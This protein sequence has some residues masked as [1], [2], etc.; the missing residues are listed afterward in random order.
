M[1]KLKDIAK[2]IVILAILIGGSIAFSVTVEALPAWSGDVTEGTPS[3][4][5]SSAL[6]GFFPQEIGS[7]GYVYCVDAGGLLRW[8]KVDRTRYFP[9]AE[10][11]IECGIGSNMVYAKYSPADVIS[12]AEEYVRNNVNITENLGANCE[13]KG[14]SRADTG[15]II[16]ELDTS[17]GIDPSKPMIIMNNLSVYHMDLMET[18]VKKVVLKWMNQKYQELGSEEKPD[19]LL[20][21]YDLEQRYEY[22]IGE[23]NSKGEV[24]GPK[25]TVIGNGDTTHYTTAWSKKVDSRTTSDFDEIMNAYI[26]NG[27][28]V[29][30]QR[31]N[32]KIYNQY[33]IQTANWLQNDHEGSRHGYNADGTGTENITT[34]GKT[35]GTSNGKVLYNEAKEY[36][37]FNEKL[38]A[39]GKY[40]NMLE[41]DAKSAQVFTNRVDSNRSLDEYIVGP[42]TIKYPEYTNI[43]YLTDIK[44]MGTGDYGETTLS[45]ASQ[46]FEITTASSEE[47]PKD[48]EMFWIR[49]NAKKLQYAEKI[50]INP[51]FEYVLYTT[52]EYNQL[53]GDAHIYTYKGHLLQGTVVCNVR[54][55]YLVDQYGYQYNI[56]EDRDEWGIIRTENRYKDTTVP[57]T[58]YQAYIEM[59]LEEYEIVDEQEIH[60]VY[61][62]HGS[63][64]NEGPESTNKTN[65]VKAKAK[66]ETTFDGGPGLID[67]VIKL[68]GYTWVDG[69]AGKESEYNGK[70]GDSQDTPMSGVKV[71]LHQRKPDGQEN[72]KETTTTD[73]NGH[74]AFEG[75]NAL[76]TYYVEFKYNGQYYQPTI[77]KANG[78][79]WNDS[80]KGNDIL[81]ERD[82]LNAKFEE[83]GSNPQNYSGGQAYTRTYLKENG[84][85]DDFGNP[86]GSN[87][88]VNDCMISAYTGYNKG[89]FTK[90]YYPVYSKFVISDYMSQ[91]N[92]ASHTKDYQANF[93]N[94]YNMLYNGDDTGY[95]NLY[96]NQGFVLRETVDLALHKDVYNATIEIKGK[97]QTYK[98]NKNDKLSDEDFW[99]I[100]TQIS[101]AY[102]SSA[103]KNAKANSATSANEYFNKEDYTREIYKEDYNFKA[104]NY[105]DLS[106][107]SQSGITADKDELRVYVTYKITVRNQSDA[108][109][110]KVMELVD[111]YD[112][113]YTLVESSNNVEREQKYKP[114]LGDRRGNVLQYVTTNSSSKYGASTQASSSEYNQTYITGFD[115]ILLDPDNNKDIYL[116]ITF[117]VNND[118]NGSVI[119]DESVADGDT[120]GYNPK[121]NIVEI[122]GYKTYYT[123]RAVAPN[124]NNDKT[125]TEYNSGDIAGL[126]DIDSI[127]GN[128]SPDSIPVDNRSIDT[129]TFED[130]TSKGPNIRIRL[131]RQN[132]RT[133]DGTVF[134][135][136]RTVTEDSS[137]IG[138]GLRDDG[139]TG[140]NGITVQLVE[141]FKDSSGNYKTDSNTGKPLEYVWREVKSG[142]KSTQNFIIGN[143]AIT[144]VD[145]TYSVQSSGQ[146][147]FKSFAPGDY[148]VRFI[149][150]DGTQSI[151]G[152]TSIDYETGETKSNPITEF[153][154]ANGYKKTSEN[155][156]YY[157][158]NGENIALNENSYNGQDYKSTTY[159]VGVANGESSYRNVSTATY[160][161]DFDKAATGLYSDAKDIYSR[162]LEVNNYSST[163]TNHFAEVLASF[164]YLSPYYNEMTDEQ[165]A[166]VI[167]SL[168]NE[169]INKTYMVAETGVM[170]IELEYNR[171]QDGDK[172]NNYT[173]TSNNIGGSNYDKNGYYDVSNVDFGLAQRPQ[174]QLK[175]TKQIANV[176]VTLANGNTLF[177][178]SKK[179]TNVMW[180]DQKAH[181][182]DKNNTYEI[183]NNYSKKDT[184]GHSVSSENTLVKIPVV[185]TVSNKGRVQLTMDEELMHGSTVQITYMITVAN[186]GEVDYS[187]VE[188]YYTGIENNPSGNIVKTKVETLVDY[189]G[190]QLSDDSNAT[191]NNLQFNAETNPDWEVVTLDALKTAGL[192]NEN[193]TDSAKQYTTIIKTK[194]SSSIVKELV[195]VLFDENNS[196][197]IDDKWNEDP[198]EVLEAVNASNSVTGVKLVLSQTITSGSN[199]DDLT[200][201]NITE[202]VK[203]S[204]VSGRRLAYSV[205]GNQDPTEEPYE[206]DA[207][208]PQE[209]IILPPFGQKVRYYALGIGAGLILIAGI[210]VTIIVTKRKKTL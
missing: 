136:E 187:D 200:Y 127:A 74:Y 69:T 126:I 117:R 14:G 198:L 183:N 162:R 18:Y 110:S 125:D 48:G 172:N 161:Y 59:D 99:D 191:R 40:E 20:D 44:I 82:G 208:S 73:A 3:Q 13:I 176:K 53:E 166:Q 109:S 26:L 134:E 83:I 11:Y 47:W 179:A 133:I 159:Q 41:L 8:G 76:Y 181:G 138:N 19:E 139:E 78:V 52:A 55:N 89:S 79:A 137:Q 203:T 178:A 56:Y 174:S 209:V 67:L 147:L 81:S 12:K 1:K 101:D 148:M 4:E 29:T 86:T 49:V 108:I 91:V 66:L 7:E 168:L 121:R 199:S 21:A 84:I 97:S 23:L 112:K 88:Y 167:Q 113:E 120:N 68:E 173:N 65:L 38:K 163:I 111:Y 152:T 189:V 165:K 106:V 95:N 195:P 28:K 10:D 210:V 103:Y 185:R 135:D 71:I 50:A 9:E 77:Y 164:E 131:N 35:K 107:L 193:L 146:Y 202:L 57:F 39:A 194:D 196:K 104:S 31:T 100:Q 188:F 15:S 80:S 17:E 190:A 115:N 5:K 22:E 201:N 60:T 87:Q 58:V 24:L 36:Y 142:D 46:D 144:N 150:G 25:V 75:L 130:D 205:A 63:G 92:R 16:Q 128:V 51:E 116:Y 140:I 114:Y 105:Q 62:I 157:S 94:I 158:V 207:D 145:Q 45:Y 64:N 192:L 37:K 204:N 96:I 6:T 149:Y 70:K 54:T 182:Q 175:T 170:N 98:Y 90:E 33:D 2:I 43:S 154:I 122:N 184:N 186:V 171:E 153:L 102:L 27:D 93:I 124:A 123:D 119:L 197:Q 34:T 155:T 151:L 32:E 42:I 141:L 180:I 118:N 72:E 177:D 143:S 160:N 129:S 169:F 156:G 85:I 206:I 30:K 61:N 132:S